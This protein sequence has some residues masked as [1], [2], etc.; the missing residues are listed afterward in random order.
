MSHLG[1]DGATVE[2]CHGAPSRTRPH[3]ALPWHPLCPCRCFLLSRRQ[4]PLSLGKTSR[5]HR[6]SRRTH[7]LLFPD[8]YLPGLEP[9]SLPAPLALFPF[10]PLNGD[11]HATASKK[12][13]SRKYCFRP[14]R[15]PRNLI[16][17]AVAPSTV[18]ISGRACCVQ[19]C[20]WISARSDAAAPAAG[21]HVKPSDSPYPYVSCFASA[22]RN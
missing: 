6:P 12:A 10:S 2:F 17:L 11:V 14:S 7:H 3:A 15:I 8:R 16:F 19:A 21:S 9:R 1:M 13:K 18:P 20:C 22:S 5:R 4:T